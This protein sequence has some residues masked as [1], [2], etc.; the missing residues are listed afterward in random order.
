MRV[1]IRRLDGTLLGRQLRTPIKIV[2]VIAGAFGKNRGEK[3]DVWTYSLLARPES[4]SKTLRQ[5]AGGCVQRA[6]QTA[7]VLLEHIAVSG[8]RL[9]PNIDDVEPASWRDIETEF[10]RWHRDSLM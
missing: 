8:C 5:I 3:I 4:R 1:G 2:V 6:I 7:V 10:E 9:G